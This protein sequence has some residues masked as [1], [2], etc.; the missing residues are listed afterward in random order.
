MSDSKN[1]ITEDKQLK[2]DQLVSES[3]RRL[4]KAALM[5]SPVIMSVAS[6][7][8]WATNSMRR[9]TASVLAS[10]NHSITTDWTTCLTC[11]PGYWKMNGGSGPCWSSTG[12]NPGD[13]FG[14]TFGITYSIPHHSDSSKTSAEDK[15]LAKSLMSALTYG[16]NNK[17]IKFARAAT[18]SYLNARALGHLYPALTIP[19]AA[20]ITSMVHY[21][22][23]PSVDHATR[24]SRAETKKN[25]LQSYYEGRENSTEC[26]L[27]ANGNCPPFGG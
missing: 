27:P 25:D 9:C 10:A 8:V 2:E 22:F 14:S 12:M 26:I 23:D 21:V 18:A 4:A 17:F 3:R 6:R 24:K 1:K 20:S 11:S 15:A 16:G 7:P 5:A 19:S 13:N